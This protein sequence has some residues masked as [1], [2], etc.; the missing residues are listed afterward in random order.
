MKTMILAA[1]KG[2]RM[3]PLT[4]STP[5]P[6]LRAGGKALIEHHLE[7]L[8]NAGF[9][10]VIINLAW[11][12]EQIEQTL[13]DGADYGLSI[14]YSREGEPLETAGGIIRALP[15][16]TGP[17]SDWFL[18]VNADIWTDF[19]FACLQPPLTP[20]T[21]ALLVMVDNPPHHPGGDF[22]LDSNGILAVT[23][24]PSL[25]FSGISLL[26]AR[27]FDG[28]KDDAGKLGPILR[29]AM[30]KGR[31]RGQYHSGHWID[32]G[33]PERLAELDARLSLGSARL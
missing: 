7:R 9:H 19:D 24:A 17:E 13:G 4:L 5:K 30:S 16:L 11:L 22:H 6:L 2:E 31:V 27:L 20:A 32:V 18:V 23:G 15:K 8:H 14:R 21:D 25:T 1:G 28:L 3:R 33:T 29:S 26:H 10:H 12:G